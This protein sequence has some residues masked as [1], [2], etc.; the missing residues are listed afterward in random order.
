MN[1]RAN[2]EREQRQEVVGGEESAGRG[3]WEMKEGEERRECHCVFDFI[4]R[5]ALLGGSR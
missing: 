4:G 1:A 3:Q 5:N 2:E